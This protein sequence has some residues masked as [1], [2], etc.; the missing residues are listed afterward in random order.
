MGRF[1][2]DRLASISTWALRIPSVRA[3]GQLH[4]SGGGL[5]VI[6]GRDPCR[7]QNGRPPM[8]SE[9]RP[10][11]FQVRP[12]S[13]EEGEMAKATVKGKGT[14]KEPWTL[15]PPPGTSEFSAFRD[16]ALDPPALVVQ[17]GKTEL[18]YQLRCI[19]DLHSMLKT[20]GDWMLLG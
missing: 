2:A 7:G 20:H 10:F 16:D 5:R 14:R 12:R 13:F 8:L 11:L 3:A 9:Q 17:V 19:D 1:A 15:K 4:W 18:R 6:L